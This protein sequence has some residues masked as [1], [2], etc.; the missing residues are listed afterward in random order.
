MPDAPGFV[1]LS[2]ISTRWMAVQIRDRPTAC[3]GGEVDEIV[4]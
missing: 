4:E 3:H 1:D 2:K